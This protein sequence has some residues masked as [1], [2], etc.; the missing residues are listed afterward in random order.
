MSKELVDRLFRK[1]EV[2]GDIKVSYVDYFIPA[3]KGI[4]NKLKAKWL[5]DSPKNKPKPKQPVVGKRG[6]GSYIK[7]K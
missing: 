5:K 1:L 4:A 2:L 3:D 6:L 7:Q